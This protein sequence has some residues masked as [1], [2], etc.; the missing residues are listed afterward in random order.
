MAQSG[1]T[2]IKVYASTTAAATPLA[3][4]LDNTNGAELAINITDGKLFYKDNGGVVQVLASKA[5]ALGNVVGPASATD[6]AIATFD[7]TTGKL[8]KDN[9][10]VTIA[11]NVITALGFSG[12]HNGTVGATTPNTGAFTTLSAS[13]TT[14]LTALTA[15]T[16]LA[17]DA[18]K[19]VVSVTNTGSGNNVLATSPTITGLTYTDAAGAAPAFAVYGSAFTSATSGV[20]TKIIFD[21]KVFDTNTNFSTT[22]YRF[23][24]TV[25]GYYQFNSYVSGPASATGILLS[26]FYKNGSRF[27]DGA[28]ILLSAG[29]NLTSQNSAIIYLNGSTDYV[30]C[31][32]FQS[33]GA[34]ASIGSQ[35]GFQQF[36]GAM[37]RSA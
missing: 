12:P 3:A 15:S 22:N 16:A 11:S 23:T 10:G 17:L 37:I 35:Y 30:E 32:G 33:S 29:A 26:T 8:I 24:P 31:Y 14:T 34:T 27:A 5:G 6:T 2:P 9:S 1:F 19:N 36:S 20:L 4:N 18:S 13:S 28:N 21:T 7:G 25:A